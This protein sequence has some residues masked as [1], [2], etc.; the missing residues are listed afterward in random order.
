MKCC[1]HHSIYRNP[2]VHFIGIE[3]PSVCSTVLHTEV[4]MC[5]QCISGLKF[6]YLILHI[7]QFIMSSATTQ[8]L[9]KDVF[10]RSFR[11]IAESDC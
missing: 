4:R 8:I 10:V 1:C 11:K 7:W 3:S 9:N 5:L 6:T 2:A